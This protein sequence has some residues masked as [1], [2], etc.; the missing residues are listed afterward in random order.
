MASGDQ[1]TAPDSP[2]TR[3]EALGGLPIRRAQALLFLIENLTARAD[4]RS[5]KAME[6][7]PIEAEA[8]EQELA[9]L[10]SFSAGRA[11]PRPPRIQD[12]ERHAADWVDQIPTDPRLR[13]AT[14]HLLGAKYRFSYEAVPGIRAAL[15]LDQE[16]V[17]RAHQRLRGAPLE[18]I[19]EAR[20]SPLDRTRWALGAVA[21]WVD[22]LPPFWTAYSLT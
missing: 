2:L 10:E 22:S 11:P 12:I 14:A 15:G 13:A 1:P 4:A 19:Y 21:R 6:L 17:K 9:F 16:A 20:T 8:E 3:Q 5:R 7:Y 18:A